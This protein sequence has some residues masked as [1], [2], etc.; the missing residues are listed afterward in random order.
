MLFDYTEAHSQFMFSSGWS[1]QSPS[2]FPSEAAE[3]FAESA[4]TEAAAA[5]A[6]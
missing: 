4:V 6:L 5:P 2:C 3:S 1:M